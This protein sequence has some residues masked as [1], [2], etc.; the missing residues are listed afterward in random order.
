MKNSKITWREGFSLVELIIVIAITC[1]LVGAVTLS[2]TLLRS[3]DTKGAAYN[4]NGRLTDLKSKNRGGKDQP[5]L[6]L[7]RLNQNYYLDVSN[8]KPEDYSPTVNAREIGDKGLKITYS[9]AKKAL[10]DA[11]NGF[12]CLAFQKKDGAFLVSGKCECPEVIYVE[13]DGAPTYAVYRVKDTGHHYIEQ[14]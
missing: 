7:S 4:I 9:P 1:I 11:P 10:E 5:Y 8:T 2:V 6:Y 14:K 13:A 3:T 12:I